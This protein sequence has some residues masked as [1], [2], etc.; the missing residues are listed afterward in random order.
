MLR[1]ARSTT[2]CSARRRAVAA[3]RRPLR[4]RRPAARSTR[5][6]AAR[7]DRLGH[8][9]RAVIQRASVIGKVF[10]WGAVA[11]L[12]PRGRPRRGV[13]AH[14]QTL[15]RKELIRPDRSGFA[16]RGRV[17]VPPPPDPRRRV[18]VHAEGGAGRAAPALRRLAR[19]RAP[20]TASPSTRR[21]SAITS[22]RRTGTG[23]SWTGATSA[24]RARGRAAA[25][26]S[27]SAGRR[28]LARWDM[29]AAANLLSRAR[30]A[31][32]RRRP[33]S[34]RRCCPTSGWRSR[35]RTSR[36]PTACS[37]RPSTSARSAGDPQ[38]E[39]RAGVR[40]SFVRSCC[41][42]ERRPIG[43]SPEVERLPGL[44]EGVAGRPRAWPEA[45][46][47]I[48]TIRFWQGRAAASEPLERAL[49]HARLAG[50][51]RQEGGDP[52]QAG[53]GDRSGSDL[54]RGGHPPIA[55]RP[56]GEPG[57]PEGRDRRDPGKGRAR[58]DAR[59]F[60]RCPRAHRPRE[61]GGPRAG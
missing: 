19:A 60:R 24:T 8:G 56:G 26:G 37:T 27:P 49:E 43:R 61:G 20:A 59:A 50:D 33:G 21:S 55:R 9:E 3:A 38:L 6:S 15:L 46:S 42:P 7:L 58:G 14:L 51:R 36:G 18:R 2:A 28:A 45:N 5:C 1:D 25:S 32:A 22:S 16:G 10:W 17:P 4:R 12:S 30:R 48:G 44:F 57:R 54:R 40:R 47:L 23:P 52:P 39:A 29:T 11:E 31:A 53:A 35:S 34:G 13:G 41:R